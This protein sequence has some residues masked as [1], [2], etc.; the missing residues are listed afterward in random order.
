MTQKLVI[1]IIVCFSLS[2]GVV[3]TLIGHS[4]DIRLQP[5]S[6]LREFPPHPVQEGDTVNVK[7]NS[8]YIAGGT[9]SCVFLGNYTAPL[10]VLKINLNNLDTQH[11]QLKVPG[12]KDQKFW[13]ARIKVDSPY[14]YVTDG[15]VPI[16]FRG[17]VYDWTAEKTLSDSVY[18][19]SIIPLSKNSHV[20]KSL[21]G[22][23]GENVLGKLTAW[24]PYQVFTD[25][26]LEKQL[27]G[28][29]C[30]DGMM[31][32]QREFNRVVYMYYYRNEFIVMDTSLNLEYRSHTIDTTAHVAIEVATIESENSKVMASPPLFVN[33]KSC[34]AGN[35]LFVNSN[36]MAKNEYPGT[37]R[38]ASVID[39]YNLSSGNYAFSFYIYNYWRRKPM[40]EFNVYGN[41]MVVLYGSVVRV[42]SLSP[43]FFI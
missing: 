34:A 1:L 24:P 20:V 6:F 35:W 43:E 19:R 40:T 42:F 41:R 17:N 8:Y 26:I 31:L 23:T 10:H 27:D 11:V 13:S 32:F 2:V 33:K 18:F 5:G 12:I 4:K 25:K 15:V 37:F 30:T 14:Y 3:A 21:S 16:I 38:K 22:K 28:V 39:V 36:L 29:F 9:S 7:F